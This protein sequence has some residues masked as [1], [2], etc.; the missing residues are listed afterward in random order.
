MSQN[1]GL[2]VSEL[3]CERDE[4]CLFRSL[5]FSLNSGEIL[6]ITGPNGSGKTTL[7]RVVAGLSL[8]F[9]GEVF[10]RGQPVA[11]VRPE[12]HAALLYMGHLLGV[13]STMTAEENLRWA[14]GLHRNDLSREEI[15]SALEKVKLAGFEDIPCYQLSAGQN[16]RVALARLFLAR[17]PLWILD[18]P[19][20]AIDKQGVAE[21]E[22]LLVDH[23][24]SG[25][26]V[27]MTTHH[28]MSLNYD[29][30]HQLVLGGGV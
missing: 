22:Q 14:M 26:M 29:G 9:T 19:F 30:F 17:Q 23:A 8:D 1:P 4:R 27:M 6:Q 12:F 5:A 3:T 2:S 11:D 13:K 18:E 16:R 24:K 28:E 10:W 7:M 25:G 21:L 15:W 20:T